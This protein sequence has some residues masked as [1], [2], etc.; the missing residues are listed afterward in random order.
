[1]L[2]QGTFM[3]IRLLN[4]VNPLTQHNTSE[5]TVIVERLN[6]YRIISSSQQALD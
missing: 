6:I 3:P 1:M 4:Q 2:P 5:T